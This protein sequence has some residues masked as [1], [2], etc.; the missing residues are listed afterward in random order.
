MQGTE[1]VERLGNNH[2]NCHPDSEIQ[3][4]KHE[5]CMVAPRLYKLELLRVEMMKNE[6]NVNK[7]GLRIKQL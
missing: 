5:A 3:T 7:T 4:H 1:T 2:Y 6:I